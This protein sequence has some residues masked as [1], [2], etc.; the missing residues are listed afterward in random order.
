MGRRLGGGR[1]GRR[2]CGLMLF[3]VLMRGAYGGKKREWKGGSLES[4][5]FH[6]L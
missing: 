2:L 6:F 4:M 3:E 5:D 1:R